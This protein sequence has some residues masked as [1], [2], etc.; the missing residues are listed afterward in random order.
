[1][2]Q[3]QYGRARSVVITVGREHDE[4]LGA[5]HAR[6]YVYGSLRIMPPT[7]ERFHMLC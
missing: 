3:L 5:A 4:R 1:M 2:H 6:R 7:R